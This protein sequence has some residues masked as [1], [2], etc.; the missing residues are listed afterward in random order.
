MLIYAN[1]KRLMTYIFPERGKT[2]KAQ[3]ILD[4]SGL[5]L[6]TCKIPTASFNC[7]MLHFFSLSFSE[8]THAYSFHKKR[9]EIL[10]KFQILWPENFRCAKFYGHTTHNYSTMAKILIFA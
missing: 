4:G 10:T 5:V 1:E 2:D 9:F 3:L 6:E 8:A 7:K